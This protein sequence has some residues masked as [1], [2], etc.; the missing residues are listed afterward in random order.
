MVSRKQEKDRFGT[1]RYALGVCV[2]LA[3]L[4]TCT[5]RVD[6]PNR[7]PVAVAGPDR[8]VTPGDSLVLDGSASYDPDGDELLEFRWR[9]P[10][11][12]AGSLARLTAEDA[13]P[14]RALLVT[15]RAGLYLVELVVSDGQKDSRPDL[16]GV[17]AS[18]GCHKDSD[19]GPC[20]KC[21]VK[22]HACV[23]QQQ[24]NDL[25]EDCPNE[26]CL[27]GSCDGQ[28]GCGVLPADSACDD[29]DPCNGADSCDD[30]GHCNHHAGSPCPETPC[31]TC[32]TDG[33]CLDPA[34]T[35][36][37]Q[38]AGCAGQGSCD[39]A[40]TCNVPLDDSYCR[41]QEH[42]SQALCLP[43]CAPDP[44]GC[45]MPPQQAALVCSPETV[46][47]GQ[48]SSCTLTLAGGESNRQEN[49]LQCQ[50]VL[51]PQLLAGTDFGDQAGQCE[52]GQWQL[53]EGSTA[54]NLCND[55]LTFAPDTCSPS[56]GAKDCCDEV[57]KICT[58]E[59]GG[60]ALYQDKATGCGT[61]HEEWRLE[62]QF[63]FTGLSNIMVCFAVAHQ[64]SDDRDGLL[65]D[66]RDDSGN[67]Q[68][69]YCFQGGS[70]AG[71]QDTFQQA[72]VG[73]LDSWANGNPAVNLRFIVHSETGGHKIFLDDVSVWGYGGG[74]SPA[75][76]SF[77]EDFTG[78]D[79]GPCSST[80]WEGSVQQCA[81]FTCVNHSGW[82]PGLEA[83]GQTLTISKR[84][85]FS[86]LDGWITICAGVG[87][88]G[89]DVGDFFGLRLDAG[90]GWHDVLRLEG[91]LGD[92]QYCRRFCTL[93]GSDLVPEVAD[94]PDVALEVILGSNS[95]KVDL[96]WLE[97]NG[98]QFC[99]AAGAV[100]M[101]PLSGD[102]LGNYDFTVTARQR[103]DTRLRCQWLG[104][105]P[106][107][108]ARLSFR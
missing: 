7:P 22:S 50:A 3:L 75:Q 78:S 70:G 51:A 105:A 86:A 95:G 12:P 48:Q 46:T 58:S 17:R 1:R 44:S 19:C 99:P 93:L 88:D 27:T 40:G 66:A 76:R 65:L 56:A 89:S 87:W 74:C 39:G 35:P 81:S 91:P 8:G 90:N 13:Q 82:E 28:G 67:Q 106:R 53:V 52:L 5:D 60:F 31:N 47:V 107:A 100:K 97:I 59:L 63:D 49:C 102:D 29:G 104:A 73:P 77:R 84:F 9:L 6:G 72:C 21:D 16:V 85:D 24:G 11:A 71:P 4:S 61:K 23:A 34:Q 41:E 98:V 69:L 26:P 45:L 54:G 92:D 55:T 80:G 101:S 68:V 42:N 83:D 25:K 103:L 57:A 14:D 96:F 64:G 43:A 15:D 30:A 18:G 38:A 33:S 79:P 37:G 108:R 36:C 20:Q 10:V 2:A 32:Q 94:N 62:R